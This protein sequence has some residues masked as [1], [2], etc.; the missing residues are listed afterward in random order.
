MPLLTRVGLLGM[1]SGNGCPVDGRGRWAEGNRCLAQWQAVR[2]LHQ[3]CMCKT[4]Q[5]A[6]DAMLHLPGSGD[7]APR[8]DSGGLALRQASILGARFRRLAKLDPVSSLLTELGLEGNGRTIG[9]I[10][11][12]TL[13]AGLALLVFPSMVSAQTAFY[14][15]LTC[16]SVSAQRGAVD[17]A[18][19]TD[20]G[21]A[22]KGNA[23]AKNG[24]GGK[25]GGG[26]KNGASGKNGGGF[27]KGTGGQNG[28]ENN[29]PS[30]NSQRDT[31]PAA[32]ASLPA[33]RCPGEML[34]DVAG[35]N[36][37]RYRDGRTEHD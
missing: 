32:N 6:D 4:V 14:G 13:L 27:K 11:V 26:F 31:R 10:R 19:A 35:A 25:N 22:V 37:K 29:G 28:T 2:T 24:P 23:S 1:A 7:A 12:T 20:S 8:G 36:W 17:K 15:M 9:M 33:E 18:S 34:L 3:M 30:A 21:A 5:T 16:D